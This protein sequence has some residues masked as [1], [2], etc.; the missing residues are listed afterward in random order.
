MFVADPPAIVAPSDENP[1]DVIEVVATRPGQAQK[2]DRRTYRV[3][4]N[5]QSAQ[6]NGIQ[7]LRG[8]PAV[9]ITPDDQILLLGTAGVTILVDERPVFGDPI[10]YLRT[11]HGSDIER[12]EIMTNPSAQ[13]A[14]GTGGVIN[15]VLRKKQE[16]G[17]SGSANA[18]VATRGRVESG[19]TIKKKRGKWSY[20]LRAEG[21]AGRSSRSIYE[22]LR[23]VQ[24]F[25]G[26]PSTINRE[27]GGG[28]SSQNSGSL[29]G[30]ITY[31]LDPRTSIIGEAFGGGGNNPSHG[32]ANFV[33][34]TPDFESFRERSRSDFTVSYAGIQLSLD[35]KGKKDGETLKAS[36]GTYGNPTVRQTIRSEFGDGD[37]FSS[38]RD[39]TSFGMF[40]HGDW[41]HP[42]GKDK[43]LSVGFDIGYFRNTFDYSFASSDEVRFGPDFRD[44]FVAS[45]VTPTAYATFQKTVGTWTIM[46]GIRFESIDRRIT[47]PG[48]AS[49]KFSR[50]NLSPTVHIEHPLSK[51]V[52]MTLSYSKRTQNPGY[53]EVSPYPIVIG[54]VAIQQGNPDLRGQT[55]DAY[56]MNLHYSRKSLEGGVILFYRE[57]DRI[58]SNIY[59]VNDEGLNVFVPVNVGT[60]LDWGA[61]FDISTPLFKRVKG[62]ASINLFS[63]RNPIDPVSGASSDTMFRYTGNATAEWHGKEKG[64]RPGDIAQVQLTYESPSRDFQIR[65][66]S[67]YSLN[68]A[69]THS[70]SPTL[71][72][73]ANL[74][75]LGPT[76]TGHRLRAPL[77]QEDYERRERLPEFKLKLVKT[78]GKQ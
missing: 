17:V 21:K 7:L 48:R 3:K 38:D 55:T 76:H 50:M 77:V 4:Q 13:Y 20:E 22:K 8:L 32:H 37:F 30:K 70:F 67:E 18:E 72:V 42:I 46:P 28:H 41:V 44:S 62:T 56:E 61:E 1:L 35:H 57:T 34:L 59:S 15:I 39:R 26:G 68:F 71:S 19:A 23:M 51:T 58:W 27:T 14:A 52:N 12:I 11:L 36:V 75:G 66:R 2:I 6:F 5:P 65:R 9:I 74:N 69:Y 78:L 63:R 16:D 25:P 29:N 24:S 45:E 33:G 53:E 73:T 49:S 64:K 47:S 43:I 10:Q 60:R 31:E 40:S 54:P